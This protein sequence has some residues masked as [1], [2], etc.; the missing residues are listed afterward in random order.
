[1]MRVLKVVGDDDGEGDKRGGDEGV[2]GFGDDRSIGGI[3]GGFV[4]ILVLVKF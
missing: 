1:M 2:S 4:V 3:G